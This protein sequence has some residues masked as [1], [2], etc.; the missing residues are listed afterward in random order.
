MI[1][2][3]Y[4]KAPDGKAEWDARQLYV[5]RLE[6]INTMADGIKT[7]I[8]LQD[9]RPSEISWY[10]QTYFSLIKQLYRNIRFHYDDADKETM[11]KRITEIEEDMILLK[12]RGNKLTIP[13]GI[14]HKL[15]QLHMDVNQKRFE[16]GLVIPIRKP[17][18]FDATEGFEGND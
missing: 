12:A 6:N 2:I 7:Q 18:R 17:E 9:G 4:E 3:D 1:P 15:E 11:D 8:E 13:S 16:V 5:R 10:Y 14:S